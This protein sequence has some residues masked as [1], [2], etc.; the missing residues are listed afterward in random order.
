MYNA[1]P[2][3]IN[4]GAGLSSLLSVP[5]SDLF[6]Q[7]I[8]AGDINL[9]HSL[10]HPSF[11]GAPSPEAENS[12]HWLDLVGLNCVSQIDVSTHNRGSVLELCFATDSS[13]A[14]GINASIEIDLDVTSD[15]FPVLISLPE[16]NRIPQ[17]PRLRF[18]TVDEK[19]F[20][21]L[22]STNLKEL[23]PLVKTKAGLDFSAS[24]LIPILY[25]AFTGS[26]KNPLLTNK[27][28]PWLN[29]SCREDKWRYRESARH[30]LP[31]SDAKKK[32]RRVVR[33]A[34]TSFFQKKLED[35]SNAK[36]VFQFTEWHKSK[37]I[38]CTPPVLNPLLPNSAPAHNLED[39]EKFYCKTC[40]RTSQTW[41]ISPF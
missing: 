11:S 13:L 32:Y 9:H 30:S 22:L 34:K 24:E 14:R 6:S 20:L 8:I 29:Q 10:W 3:A 37:G 35:A 17:S 38:F 27:G 36:D 28:Q 41:K 16:I 1:P 23:S 40:Y 26:A 4:P 15:H 21:A 5:T 33:K 7:T 12:I 2:G 39:K 19:T 25:S 31:S 18:L